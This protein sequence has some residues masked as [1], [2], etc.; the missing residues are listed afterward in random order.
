MTD[1]EKL[2]ADDAALLASIERGL[3]QMAAGDVRVT[4]GAEIA[5]RTAGRPK[6]SR[7]AVHK[8]AI[9]LRLAPDVLARWRATGKGWQTRMTQVLCQAAP[10]A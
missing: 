9:T 3:T 2:N 5:R 4:T 7:A 1:T 8:E 6:G 10:E